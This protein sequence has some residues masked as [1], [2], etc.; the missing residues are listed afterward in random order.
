MVA[1][2]NDERARSEWDRSARLILML[3]TGGL[4]GWVPP[5]AAGQTA[6]VRIPPPSIG[7]RA[8]P[9]PLP[10]ELLGHWI[11]KS[12]VG[13]QPT[14]L[15]VP[16]AAAM[17][18]RRVDIGPNLT[19]WRVFSGTVVGY[20][21]VQGTLRDFLRVASIPTPKDPPGADRVFTFYTVGTKDCSSDGKLLHLGDCPVFVLARDPATEEVGLVTM[22]GGL[23]LFAPAPPRPAAGRY[24]E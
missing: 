3:L 7:G 6:L 18:G 17:V 9:A 19:L 13:A 12:S 20:S 24:D 11:V 10:V 5:P 2:A 21:I 4:F 14:M 23:A 15:E 8:M 22:P 16:N 1:A